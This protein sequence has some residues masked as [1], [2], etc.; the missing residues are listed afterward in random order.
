M[1]QITQSLAK[2]FIFSILK[3]ENF[4]RWFFVIKGKQFFVRVGRIS[5]VELLLNKLKTFTS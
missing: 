1:R 3:V 2:L 4:I 5:I